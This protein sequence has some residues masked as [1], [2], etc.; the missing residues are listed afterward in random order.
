MEVERMRKKMLS[1]PEGGTTNAAQTLDSLVNQDKATGGDKW[2]DSAWKG[3]E[4]YHFL[5]LAQRQLYASKPRDAMFTALRLREYESVLPAEEIYSLIALT[6]C[7]AKFYGQC[8]KAF[9]RLQT[10]PLSPVKK[11]EVNKL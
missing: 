6:A 10:L 8:S 4:A 1:L 11:A 7:Y 2:L 5:L 9:V 3:A